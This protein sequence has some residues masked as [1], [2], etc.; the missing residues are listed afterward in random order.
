VNAVRPSTIIS[1]K[2]RYNSLALSE[3]IDPE[4][5]LQK[6]NIKLPKGYSLRKLPKD[7]SVENDFVIYKVSFKQDKNGLYVEKYQQF[8]KTIIPVDEFEKFKQ[9]YLKLLEYDRLKITF[10]VKK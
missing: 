4:P 8:K 7:I 5:T 6:V 1:S 10:N 2:K 9:T 3:I